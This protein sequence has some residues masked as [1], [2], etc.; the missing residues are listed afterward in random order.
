MHR[1][2]PRRSP[3]LR[4]ERPGGS[5]RFT[6]S[7]SIRLTV[8]GQKRNEH[9]GRVGPEIAQS[10]CLYSRGNATEGGREGEETE[11]KRER[12]AGKEGEER[13]VGWRKVLR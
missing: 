2:A 8:T 12:E 13:A 6:T 4:G 7:P 1:D 5:R 9:A 10:G 11:R 3:A